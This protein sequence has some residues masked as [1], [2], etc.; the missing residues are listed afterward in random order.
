MRQVT[1]SIPDNKYPLFMELA[2]SLSFVK[3]IEVDEDSSKEKV[4]KGI[5]QSVKE[6]NLV[7]AGKLKPRNARDLI[8]EL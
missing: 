1:L 6:V 2:R 5:K 8:S 3:K 4:L 7:K